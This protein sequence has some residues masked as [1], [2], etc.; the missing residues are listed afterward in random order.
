MSSTYISSEIS[1]PI[2]LLVS[3]FE[4]GFVIFQDI[5]H[6]KKACRD[7]FIHK[8]LRKYNL[9]TGITSYFILAYIV[10]DNSTD[11]AIF[12]VKDITIIIYSNI[13]QYQYRY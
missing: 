13:L 4:C 11:I 2:G 7:V 9:R 5:Y 12:A 3:A 8:Q 1:V 6:I 10:F